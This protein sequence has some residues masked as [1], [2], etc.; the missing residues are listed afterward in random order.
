M[1]DFLGEIKSQ[2]QALR[3]TL[4]YIINEGKNQFLILKDFIKKGGITKFIFTGMGSS[5]ISGY[6]PYYIL[7]QYGIA[8]EMREAGEFLFNTFPKVKKNCFKD[9][10]IIIISQ[11]GESGEIRELLREINAIPMEFKPLTVGITNNPDSYLAYMTELQ[12]FMNFDE[13]VSVTSKS[14]ICTLLI[15]YAMAKTII[16]EF[17]TNDQQTQKIEKLIIELEELLNNQNTIDSIWNDLLNKFGD[18]NDFIEI[19]ARG[20]SLTT[21]YQA[22]LNYKEIVKGYSEANS[23]STF[24]HG[25]IECLNDSSKVILL[26]S[27]Q[28]NL[29]LNSKFL[30]NIVNQWRCDKI[31][32]ITNQNFDDDLEKL[33]ESPKLILYKHKIEDPHLAPI[34]EIV[35]LQLLFYKIAEKRGIEPGVFFFS[36]KITDDI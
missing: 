30:D 34:F 18:K 11:S 19:L 14:Y 33:H 24:R 8:V 12:I 3:D 9:S 1:N 7:N 2:P 22:A 20:S 16:G 29:Q 4:K 25:G 6:L 17:F 36:Q 13:E 31:L 5:F 35:V 23:I 32:H 28:K 15:L 26:T 21:A 27:D 10:G